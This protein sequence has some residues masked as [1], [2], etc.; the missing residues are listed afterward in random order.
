MTASRRLCWVVDHIQAPAP[1]AT[2]N[3]GPRERPPEAPA[4][5]SVTPDAWP[6]VTS[7]VLDHRQFMSP[8]SRRLAIVGLM[9]VAALCV[10]L[11]FW[12]VH[13]LGERRA[14][15]RAAAAAREKPPVDLRGATEW[16][17]E[18]LVNRWVEALGSYDR[19]HEIVLR[20]Q[21]FQGT[22][23]VHVVTPLR[24]AG[25]EEAVLVVRGFVP[26]NDAV[27]AETA[28][29]S[30]PGEVLVRGLGMAMASG[31]GEPIAHAGSTTW[32]RLDLGALRA[33]IPYP[34]LPVALQQLPDSALP[35]SPR[36]LPVVAPSEG[37]HL[38]YAVQWFLFAAM[39]AAF[40][41][42]VVGR[43]RER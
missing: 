17:A 23:G 11:G 27:R 28:D 19:E 38:G 4:P 37:S 36:R 16:Q 18:S 32:A 39:A 20:G 14:L 10:R 9:L 2:A 1:P 22:P 34:V 43:T 21:A 40:A 13:R 6:I 26:A 8:V 25:R 30:E 3:P 5:A 12:Q 41:I 42:L 33:R 15:N 29:L 7:H 24:L 31:R 35:R